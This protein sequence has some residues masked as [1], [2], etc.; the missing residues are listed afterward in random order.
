MP[1]F[2][3]LH[4]I[5]QH[6]ESVVRIFLILL[7]PKNNNLKIFPALDGKGLTNPRPRLHWMLLI[8]LILL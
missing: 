3:G 8:I 2:V 5:A 7:P 6:T 1:P 4:K